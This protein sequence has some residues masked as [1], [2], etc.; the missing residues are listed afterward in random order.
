MI[1]STSSL[2]K[3]LAFLCR[4]ASSAEEKVCAADVADCAGVAGAAVGALGTAVA[5]LAMTGGAASGSCTGV[6]PESALRVVAASN[7]KAAKRVSTLRAEASNAPA[8]P[9]PASA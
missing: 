1:S 5:A 4:S 6:V 2:A 8:A 9:V 7:H 3:R